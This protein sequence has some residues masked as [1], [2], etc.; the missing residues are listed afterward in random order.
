MI[1]LDN[2]SVH[3]ARTVNEEFNRDFEKR[4]LPPYSCTLNPIEKL[5]NV[6]K[7]K[8]RKTVHLYCMQQDFTEER[9]EAAK[10]R[11]LEIIETIE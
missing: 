7:S 6:V 2:L 1:V 8:W 9:L 5:W 10:L 11:I 3:N 4:L